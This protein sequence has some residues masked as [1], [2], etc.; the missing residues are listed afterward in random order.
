MAGPGGR[1]GG[2]D[3]GG[4]GG[5][6]GGGALPLALRLAPSSAG[7]PLRASLLRSVSPLTQRCS[8]RHVSHRKWSV[9]GQLSL[10]VRTT[11]WFG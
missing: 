10:S 11:T 5:G 9:R 3:G 6:G 2:G 8:P 1:G 7:M 4:G